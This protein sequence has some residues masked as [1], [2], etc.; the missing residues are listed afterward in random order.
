MINLGLEVYERENVIQE[1]GEHFQKELIYYLANKSDPLKFFITFVVVDFRNDKMIYINSNTEKNREIMN[2]QEDLERYRLTKCPHSTVLSI[3]ERSFL[4]FNEDEKFFTYVDYVDKKMTVYKME[5][6]VQ[7][8]GASFEKISHT[9]YKDYYDEKY[10]FLSVVDSINCLHIYRISIDLSDI[11]EVDSFEGKPIPPH[12]LKNYK[13]YF[14]LSDEF[15]YSHFE[16][17][18]KNKVVT[19]DELSRMYFKLS[20]QLSME[21]KD[22]TFSQE[23]HMLY[24]RMREKF[25]V[26]CI[27][28]RI[29][30]INRDTKEQKYYDTTG[31]SPAHFE[32]YD[33]GGEEFV[34]TSAHNFFGV[35]DGVI[36]FEPAVIDKYKIENN[37]LRHVGAFSHEMGYRYTSHKLF[38]VN[39]KTYLC[40]FGQPN[41]LMF[42]DADNMELYYYDDIG[43]NILGGHE[44]LSLF[45]NSLTSEHDIVSIEVSQDSKIIVFVDMNYLYFYDFLD[46]KILK[47]IPHGFE[48]DGKQLF[49]DDITIR[50]THM[51]YMGYQGD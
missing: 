28:G 17:T 45:I 6:L 15:R 22:L 11:E 38:S 24:Q 18:K 46:R 23:R 2:Q 48:L 50:T 5:D 10:F 21:Y 39:G 42:V 40:T 26:K 41:R 36:Y 30:M 3:P 29:L 37:G 13:N 51:D 25:G 34:Y 7:L 33:Q 35:K 20:L 32:I 9:F 16:L 27:N 4:T 49:T 1:V 44:D 19:Q 12:V 43:E 14:F 8:E 31:G 47:K